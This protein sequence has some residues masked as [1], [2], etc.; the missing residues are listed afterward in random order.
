MCRSINHFQFSFG[1]WKTSN[2]GHWKSLNL[3]KHDNYYMRQY[4]CSVNHSSLC[5][6]IYSFIFCY[7]EKNLNINNLGI[8]SSVVIGL[9]RYSLYLHYRKGEKVE[10]R[11]R[12]KNR[13]PLGGI[14]F[15]FLNLQKIF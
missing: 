8:G 7:R 3:M 15:S 9:F 5:S 2:D 1:I 4:A 13:S 6:F 12:I 11:K 10:G 14:Y